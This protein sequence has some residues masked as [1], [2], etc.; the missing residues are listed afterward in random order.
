MFFFFFA[1]L[2]LST[3]EKRAKLCVFD[4]KFTA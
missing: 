2:A 3:H 1:C 4:C